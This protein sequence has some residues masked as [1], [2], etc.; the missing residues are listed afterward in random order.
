[1]LTLCSIIIT[2]TT[3]THST[4]TQIISI[5]TVPQL[6][7]K[8]S[9]AFVSATPVFSR[10]TFTTKAPVCTTKVTPVFTTRMAL[11]TGTDETPKVQ[12][13]E[14]AFSRIEEDRVAKIES[15][16]RGPQ[17]FTPYA[18][19][20]NGRMAM[21]GFFIG[22][23]TEIISG[24]PIGQQMLIMFS[25]LTNTIAALLHALNF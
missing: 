18:E 14:N 1:M 24:K 25:P 22:L 19:R 11:P 21:I 10:T 5:F 3:I 16:Y 15:A 7:L 4:L 2:P 12:L 8:M 6:N 20:V 23:V 9:F 17:G 13:R